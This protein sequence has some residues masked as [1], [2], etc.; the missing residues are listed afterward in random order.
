M[1]KKKRECHCVALCRV[2][3]T[4][5]G[6]FLEVMSRKPKDENRDK[7]L[8]AHAQLL[9]VHFNHTNK[10][11]RRVA[12]RFLAKLVDKF[13]H[14][15][16]SRRVLHT[17]L[18]I[19]QVLSQSLSLDANEEN[20]TLALPS[21]PYTLVLMDTLEAREVGTKG[22]FVPHSVPKLMTLSF[23]SFCCLP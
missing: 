12:D 18:D 19:L 22:C 6:T 1:K 23:D 4:V 9:L 14:L 5:F 13:P 8:E 10:N 21:T 15:L 2:S 3:E 11:I 20:P 7:D 17:M 16:W